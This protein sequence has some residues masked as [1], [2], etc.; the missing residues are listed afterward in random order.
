V[1]N[2]EL[3]NH[4]I[5]HVALEDEMKRSYLDY[6]MSV[7]VSRALPDIRDG[8]KP[9]HR[10]ILYAMHESGY[11]AN[12]PLR[13]SAR[14]VGDVMGKY[15]PH[16][17][18][19]IYE[20]MV[21]MAQDFAMRLPLIQGQGN[22]GSID[23]DEAAAM[24]YTEA[25]LAKSADGLL[26]DIDKDTVLFQPNYDESEQEPVVLPAQYPNI[27]VN[28]GGGIAVGMATNIPPHNLGEVI[29]A[30]C[31]Y[32]DDPDIDIETLLTIIPG[33]D[34]PTGGMIMGRGGIR[35][36][37]FTGRGSVMMRGRVVIEQVRKDKTA[38]II[39]EIPYQVN[40][41]RMIERI[42]EVVRDKVIEGISDIRDESDRDGIRVVIELK[43]DAEPDVVLNQ[44]YRLT[45]LQTSFGA[46]ILALYKG[47][48]DVF[49]LKQ[50]IAAFIEFREEVIVKRTRFML[51]KAQARSHI[52]VGLL[53]AVANIDAMIDLIRKSAD[54]HV[55]REAIMNRK[56]SSDI[57]APLLALTHDPQHPLGE[58]GYALSE[59]QA[60]AILELR[61]QRLTGLERQKLTDE[62]DALVEEMKEY[63][64]ILGSRS[65]L[66]DLMKREMIAYKEAFATPRRTA[67]EDAGHEQDDEDLIQREDMIVTV[68]HAGYI[69]RVPLSTYRAQKRGGRGRA[70]MATRDED[71]VNNIFVA[72]THTPILF[73]TSEGRVFELKVYKLPLGNPQA[74]GKAMIN[75][76]PLKQGEII[77][78]VMHL[79]N[80]EDITDNMCMVFA[81]SSGSVRRNSI[82]DFLRIKS[83][84]KIAMKL[85]DDEKLVGV[86]TCLDQDDVFLTTRLGK[87]IRFSIGEIRVFVG[88]N[89][90]GVRG[91]RLQKTDEVICLSVLRNVDA[92]REERAAY[93][94]MANQ[95]RRQADDGLFALPDEENVPEITISEER[96]Q[97]LAGREQVILTVTR[98]GYA[99]RSSAYEYRET[100]RGGQGIMNLDLTDKNGEVVAAYP[101]EHTDH[102]VVVTDRGQIIRC[103]VDSIRLAGRTTQGVRLF[104]L[105]EQEKVVSVSALSEDDSE[106]GSENSENLIS[107][108]ITDEEN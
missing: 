89:S 8:L 16:G 14:I 42:A 78:T 29:E 26:N 28:G 23:G 61:L 66:F 107:E 33:P 60:R 69:K 67:I 75:I 87:C 15:H 32:I 92:T 47:K 95:R 54:P 104:R 81:T 90:T 62:L 106:E 24:R 19:P 59:I 100:G 49:N 37:Y 68:S 10:R 4:D 18:S 7:I 27:L 2:L 101:V 77:S 64:L 97:E 3:S 41:S 74:K 96:F 40:K 91:I 72:N 9:V 52:L 80:E 31:A 85:E 38:I 34:F 79:P 57:I 36:A 39:N 44:L 98:K 88:R 12:R 30:C 58:E 20:S 99:K 82:K 22:F 70:G 86:A 13:K 43:R 73:F 50:I 108:V 55:A 103:A 84:G 51:R 35:N 17:D 5:K 71:F 56:W 46:N 25:R 102:V 83:N 94:K 93:L 1:S 65:Y 48:P 45:P 11:T 6:A 21:R 105:A 63:G 53:M 76:L